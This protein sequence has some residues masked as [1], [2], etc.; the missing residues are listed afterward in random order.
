MTA[1]I[2]HREGPDEAM[3]PVGHDVRF[4]PVRRNGD[5]DLPLGRALLL[6]GIFDGPPSI[7]V[8]LGCPLRV[9]PDIAGL[10]AVLDLGLLV[11]RQPLL[12]RADKARVHQLPMGGMIAR[13]RDLGIEGREQIV[14][15]ARLLQG[16]PEGPDRVAIRRF[17]PQ[18]KPQETHVGQPVG[19]QK[20]GPL[21]GKVV[22]CLQDQDLQHH[23][24]VEWRATAFRPV[25]PHQR[26][27]KHRAKPLEINDPRHHLKRVAQIG[28][29]LQTLVHVEKSC[30]CHP[31]KESQIGLTGEGFWRCPVLSEENR[32]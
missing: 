22:Q 15:D 23:H 12:R 21:V 20:L 2:G 6:L 9:L 19:D 25:R 10:L 4:V 27:V 26:L 1:G 30:L 18:P 16:L 3:G 28:N 14:D 17:I 24:R 5:I 31:N 8:L 11:L 29:P 32:V 7:G 13:C